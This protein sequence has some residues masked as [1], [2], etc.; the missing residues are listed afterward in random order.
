MPLKQSPV[1]LYGYACH[2]GNATMVS[3]MLLAARADEKAAGSRKGAEVG[4]SAAA[5]YTGR[6]SHLQCGVVFDRFQ[7][8]RHT[9][10]ATS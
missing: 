5:S 4:R 6:R 1:R 10:T 2:E 7:E 3:G 8:L 9:Q